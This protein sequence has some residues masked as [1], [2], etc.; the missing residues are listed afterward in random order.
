MKKSVLALS[1]VL[2]LSTAFG[3]LTACKDPEPDPVEVGT[4]DY[5]STLLS[6]KENVNDGFNSNL[7]YVNTLDFQVAD[8]TVIYITEGEDK[9]YFYCYGT[10]DE[11]GGYG[12]QAWRSKDLARWETVGIAYKPDFSVAWDSFNH[13][14]PEIIYDDGLY[15]LFFNA[16]HTYKPKA[17]NGERRKYLSVV[18][19]E[20]PYGPFKAPNRRNANGE[21][22]SAAE[23]VFDFSGDNPVLAAIEAE[24]NAKGR[25]GLIM[26]QTIDASP[27]KDPV[28][29]DKYLFW[30]YYDTYGVG[31]FQY[32]V[33]MKDW[34]TPDYSTIT[35]ITAPFYP[36]VQDAL[37][38]NVTNRLQEGNVN[39][40]GYM[41]YHEGR[42]YLTMSIF[43]FTDP[44]Y[45]VIQAVSDSP[46]G[47]EDGDH[48]SDFRKISVNDGGRVLWTNPGLWSHIVSA[49]HHCFITVGDELYT[50]Y[51][52]FRDRNSIANGRAISID[53]VMWVENSEGIPVMH[54]NGPT[55]SIQP[56]PAELSGYDNIATSATITATNTAEGS[57]VALL[58][59]EIIKYHESD[60]A[61][62]YLANEGT[63]TITLTWDDFKTVRGLMIYNS[64][65]YE[66]TFDSVKKVELEYKQAS[67][68]TAT[69]VIEDLQYDWDWFFEDDWE[70]IR[71]G[72]SAL[73]EFDE[74]PVK[75]ITITVDSVT[76][77][78]L[79][80][81]EIIV[82]GKDEACDGVAQFKEYSYTNS[83]VGSPHIIVEGDKIGSIEGTN[84]QTQYGYD[85]THDDGTAD[86]YFEQTMCEDQSAF[87]KD[88][89]GTS[90][91]VE[92][93]F[94]VTSLSPFNNDPYPK[95]GLAV[96]CD[97]TYENTIFFY[98]DAVNFSLSRVGVAQ[99]TLD[100]RDWDWTATERL[101]EI[102]QVSYT[103][104]NYVK[105][106]I[107]RMGDKFW[108]LAEDVPV[109]FYDNFNVF[110]EHQNGAVG[111]RSFNTPMKIMNYSLTTDESVLNEMMNEFEAQ[112]SGENF[113]DAGPF[114]TGIGWDLTNDR[115]DDPYIEQKVSG[116]QYAFFKNLSST[117]FYV[118]T[119]IGA[120]TDMGDPWPKFGLAAQVPGN[121]LFFYIDASA[122]F[123]AQNIG[124]VSRNSEDT[125]WTWKQAGLAEEK[126][127]SVG[128]YN[129]GNFAK[130]GMLREGDTFYLF[131]NDEL[132]FTVSGLRGFGESDNCSAAIMTFTMGA[133]AK[134]YSATTDATV[135]AAKKDELL[136]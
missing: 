129:N 96:S 10:S 20:T 28:T 29:G 66:T 113:G 52:T 3:V 48:Y 35:R 71:P 108:F 125:E 76:G 54:T 123:T 136:N 8:P 64:Y 9:G 127:A 122:S 60:L 105:L 16:D 39:E 90:F 7:F 111:F 58:N 126:M 51:H 85:A 119:M 17:K 53:K 101:E 78:D 2:A 33:K 31:S 14:A 117:N 98:V 86:A 47:D 44:N 62:E 88:F 135:I 59:D 124:W 24:E 95:F 42:Y 107:L 46:L 4:F 22:L 120:T 87:F 15:Y 91:Y 84:L 69:A 26:E 70:F 110:D 61:V 72:G 5:E 56:L 36:T 37:Q 57:D 19:S 79:A 99:R 77:S 43:G 106:G 41:V 82:L 65:D 103:N 55:W 73:A 27:F 116:D 63:S 13:W 118:E 92:A 132:V 21:Q 128:N 34:Y 49:G 12:I 104:D 131:L 40:G 109:I 67:G 114:W 30:S 23:P 25:E 121:T 18:V 94:T 1:A 81:G 68:A 115:G 89:Y 100:N 11:I 130:L 112:V 6:E 75:S 97:D 93:E 38:G 83:P 80:L 32:G 133:R 45:Q 134:E 74:L 102:G 50:A